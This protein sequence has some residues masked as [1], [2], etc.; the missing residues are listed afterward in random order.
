MNLLAS[1]R[2][3]AKRKT[4]IVDEVK[5]VAPEAAPVNRDNRRKQLR[6]P[7]VLLIFNF[8]WDDAKGILMGISRYS[9]GNWDVLI[10][11]QA[12][13]VEEDWWVRDS[14][15]DGIITRHTSPMLVEVCRARHIPLIDLNDA[16]L[17]PDVPKI[18]PDNLAVGHMGAE[19]FLER[20]FKHFA[21][22]GLTESWAQERRAG[23]VEALRLAG[24]TCSVL[25]ADYRMVDPK[26]DV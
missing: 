7:R 25:E 4:Q 23:F 16:P 10:D 21:F 22:C 8:C 13:A 3:P 24:H 20:G 9:H 19:H 18:R 2:S 1:P 15:W 14:D 26:W 6:R 12:A 17:I 5:V 11:A